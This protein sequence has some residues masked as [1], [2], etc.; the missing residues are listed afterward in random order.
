MN[1]PVLISWAIPTPP[2]CIMLPNVAC[3]GTGPGEN[4][5]KCKVAGDCSCGVC[6]VRERKGLDRKE[7]LLGAGEGGGRRRTPEGSGAPVRERVEEV[8]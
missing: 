2:L 3:I 8:R 6:S 5:F 1:G 4:A 7:V